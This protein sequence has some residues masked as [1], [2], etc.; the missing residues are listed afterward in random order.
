MKLLI[1]SLIGVCAMKG[2]GIAEM[3]CVA[4]F[5]R[6]ILELFLKLSAIFSIISSLWVN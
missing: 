2:R 4:V 6:M 1:S 5:V 3:V